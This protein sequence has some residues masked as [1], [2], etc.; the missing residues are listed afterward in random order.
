MS[1]QVETKLGLAKQLLVLHMV[2]LAMRNSS[3][4][5]LVHLPAQDHSDGACTVTESKKCV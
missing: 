4:H 3:G 1:Q 2:T 5:D